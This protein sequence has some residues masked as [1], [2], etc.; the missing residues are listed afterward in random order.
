MHASSFRGSPTTYQ[1][2]NNRQ[3]AFCSD[4]DRRCPLSG[5]ARRDDTSLR[6]ATAYPWSR[7]AARCGCPG[8]SGLLYAR[9]WRELWGEGDDRGRELR[10]LEDDELVKRVCLRTHAGRPLAT[11]A[12]APGHCM[13]A[14]APCRNTT[15]NR[16]ALWAFEKLDTLRATLLCRAGRFTRPQGVLTLTL[17]ANAWARQQLADILKAVRSAA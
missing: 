16:A 1:R 14:A 17:N 11:V 12:G 5:P 4:D 8:R 10:R 3:N 7:A 15:A 2:G 13:D 9:L 6:R